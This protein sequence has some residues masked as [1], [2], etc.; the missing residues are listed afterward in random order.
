MNMARKRSRS[1]LT[2][3]ALL[4]IAVIPLATSVYLVGQV[5]KVSDSVTAGQTQRLARPLERAAEAKPSHLS[6]GASPRQYRYLDLPFIRTAQATF[7][8]AETAVGAD[9]TLL[10]RVRHARL[11]RGRDVERLSRCGARASSS[12]VP[13]VTRIQSGSYD[14]IVLNYANPDMV[15]HTGVMEAAIKACETVD[16]CARD[17]ITAGLENGYTTL[18]IADHGN[19]DTMVNPDGSPNTAHTTNPVPLILVDPDRTHIRSGV[20]GDV[21][22]TLLDILGITPPE[23]MTRKSL[24][25]DA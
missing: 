5:I 25:R 23:A 10:R 2:L 14:L 9:A 18:V 17:V 20:L 4:L 13:T 6:M 16:A 24:L 3:L 19:C 21:A 1:I 8:E 22:P 7:D 11:E 15:G 12:A